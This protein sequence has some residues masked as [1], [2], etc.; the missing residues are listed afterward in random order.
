[1]YGVE[2]RIYFNGLSASGQHPG[3]GWN[4]DGQQYCGQPERH[5]QFVQGKASFLAHW[6]LLVQQEVFHLPGELGNET[7]SA[8]LPETPVSRAEIREGM[9][10]I[11]SG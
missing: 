8:L 11:V 7:N 4:T 3:E 1:V 10:D 5:E 6:D 2:K 9:R